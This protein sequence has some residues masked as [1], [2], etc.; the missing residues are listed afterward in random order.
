MGN[1]LLT[2]IVVAEREES[3]TALDLHT[4]RAWSQTAVGTG[5]CIALRVLPTSRWGVAWYG[6]VFQLVNFRLVE[7][8]R[9]GFVGIVRGMPLMGSSC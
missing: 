7:L 9:V 4:S 1:E 3:P 6:L 8:V 5:F 2:G